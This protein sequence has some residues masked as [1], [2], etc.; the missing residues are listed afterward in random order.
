MLIAQISD[1]HIL[2]ESS[3]LP[4]AGPRAEDLRRCVADINRLDPRPELV[5][6]TGDTVQTGAAADY[7]HL[8]KLLSPLEPPLY[9]TI[10]NRDGQKNFRGAFG[11]GGG[12]FLQ[13]AVDDLSVRLIALDSIE[14]LQNKGVF[15]ADR[16]RWLDRTLAAAPDRPTILFIHHPPFDLEPDYY[17]GYLEPTD[18]DALASVIARHRQVRRLLCGHCHR[19]TQI[20]WAGT[21]ASTM[22]SVARDVRKGVDE[23]RYGDTPIY[24]LHSVAENGAVQTETRLATA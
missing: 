11:M 15:C 4:E 9:P 6:H 21:E 17:N 5:I 7:A 22:T 10:G 20:D 24:L 18:R 19:T 8:R 3:D 16:L 14:A 1:T 13:Y 12:R 23:S 2:A